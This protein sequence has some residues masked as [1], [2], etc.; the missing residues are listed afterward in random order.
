MHSL[1]A[2]CKGV[3]PDR[4][5]PYLGR[6]SSGGECSSHHRY[7]PAVGYIAHLHLLRQMHAGLPHRG[8]LPS[9]LNGRRDAARPVRTRILDHGPGEEAMDRLKLATMWLGGCSGCHMS[10]LDLDEFLIDL[11]Q[12]VDIVYTPLIDIKTFPE[13]VDV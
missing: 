4:R 2:L 6:R 7:A 8:D 5:R 11:T 12:L 3:R 10:F 9:G 13:R 1:H